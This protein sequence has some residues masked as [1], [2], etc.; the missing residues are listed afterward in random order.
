MKKS[1]AYAAMCAPMQFEL[2]FGILFSL[3]ILCDS[4]SAFQTETDRGFMVIIIVIRVV[5]SFLP[6]INE[7]ILYSIKALVSTKTLCIK[8]VIN[9]EDKCPLNLDKFH[10]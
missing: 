6:L 1:I 7:A 3:K 9:M 5:S 10:L 4:I 2:M 8:A